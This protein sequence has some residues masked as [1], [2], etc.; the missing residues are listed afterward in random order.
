MPGPL[1]TLVL[2]LTLTFA[3]WIHPDNLLEVKTFI[4]PRL[5]A[6]VYSA[7]WSKDANATEDPTITS[8]Y[9]DSPRFDLYNN[10][11][12]RQ[13]A[14]SSL[15]IRWYGQL[16]SGPP[17]VLEKKTVDERGGSVEMKMQIKDKYIKPFLD[18]EYNMEKSV[19]K[20]ERQDQAAEKIDEFKTTVDQ[21]RSFIDG[22]RLSPV[23]RANYVR[24]AFQQPDDDRI[25]ISIDTNLAFIREDTLDA[26]RP[27]R[28]PN[29]WHRHD[30]DDNGMAY[31]FKDVRTGEVSKFPYSVLEIK[32]REDGTRKHPVWVEDLMASHLVHPAP[33]F[34][35]FVHGVA[36]LFDDYVNKNP[37]W[38]ADLERDIRKDPQKAFEADAERR[39]ERAA[40]EE[41]VGS[42]LGTKISSYKPSRSSPI[43]QSYL[44][45]RLAAE[46]T[47]LLSESARAAQQQDGASDDGG[48]SSQ[49]KS[50]GT[51]SSILPSFSISRYSK[52]RRAQENRLPEGVVEPQQWLKNTG[53]L[54]IEPKVWLANERTFLKWQHICVLLGGLGVSLYSAAGA[55]SIAAVMGIVYLFVAAFA[56]IWG[57]V[58]LKKRREMIIQRSGKDFDNM[59]GPIIISVALMI[60]LI[61]NLFFQWQAAFARW[62]SEPGQEASESPVHEE[63]R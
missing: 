5:P 48:D 60:A 41:V 17:L 33:R 51:I 22:Q 7:Q 15:R 34:S 49:A 8:L 18:G 4:L 39:A 27:C 29:S 35:K 13:S 2:A 31:P 50:Y 42:F 24:T 21:L 25:R 43:R 14:A 10:K 61:L 58:M 55:G 23:V 16:S 54:K 52:A 30:I 19:S 28:D 62:G 47:S 46:S 36:C 38:M 9:F 40:G 56:G 1:D 12:D 63:L 11:I 45:S 6:L 57:Y 59:V 32:I 20:M 26:S 37:F 44:S 3:V 53:E